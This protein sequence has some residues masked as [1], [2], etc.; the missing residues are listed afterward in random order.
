MDL[1]P[2]DKAR[3]LKAPIWDEYKKIINAE[4]GK[5]VRLELCTT[6]ACCLGNSS[7]C[8]LLL[9]TILGKLACL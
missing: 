1:V 9:V 4:E 5:Q 7:G 6:V 2:D 3:G 8:I